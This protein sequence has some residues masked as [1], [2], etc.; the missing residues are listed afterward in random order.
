MA[1]K[2]ILVI[3]SD[4]SGVGYYR[5]LAPHKYIA[6]HYSDEF[7]VD[8]EYNLPNKA[9]DQYFKDYDL[10]IFHK[11]LDNGCQYIDYIKSLGIPVICDV[12][13]YWFLGQNHPMHI[14]STKE[15]W[16]EPIIAHLAK[17]DCVTTTTPIFAKEIRK[18]NKNVVVFPNAINPEEKQFQPVENPHKRV[19]VGLICGSTH[20]HDIELLQ[21]IH[22][23]IPDEV[24]DKIQFVLCGFDT[25]GTTTEYKADGTS[26]TRNIRPEESTWC[27]Y[28]RIFT[29]NYK[30]CSPQYAAYL[31]MYQNL[32]YN[33]DL[34]NEA[35][36][37]KWT[38]PIDEYA[39]HY[40]DIDILLAP[41]VENDFNKMKSQLKEIECGF[42]GKAIIAQE[43]AAY[44][45]DMVSAIEK[46]GTINPKGNAL[47][48]P[49]SKNHKLWSKY[50]TKLVTD[51]ELRNM[52]S[53]NLH[54]M[55][56][57]KYSME[58]VCQDRVALYRKLISEHGK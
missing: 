13:D 42:F 7:T 45:I 52:I 17:A 39:T 55:V 34:S 38:K 43:F 51:D 18:H 27:A 44:T 25:R 16:H 15:K 30:I 46:G 8:I 33:G 6:E 57:E 41:L 20:L 40:N 49:S 50:I 48:V 9:I 58:A 19:R 36:V 21:N 11:K 3:P 26:T 4:K 12:D 5:S 28:E 37:R 2:R 53:K 1:K 10:V 22:F 35:Y 32:P 24:K 54:D 56:V 14:A 47:L 29:D 31:K 23:Q